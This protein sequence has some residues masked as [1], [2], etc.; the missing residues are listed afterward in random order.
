MDFT[1]LSEAQNGVIL[2][3][4]VITLAGVLAL[5]WRRRK[6]E[7]MEFFTTLGAAFTWVFVFA[8][9]AGAQYMV[10]FAPFVLLLSPRWWVA[11]TA[12]SAI[13]MAWFYDSTSGYVF[14][15]DFSFPKGPEI[16]YW[17][18]W[19]N[20]AWGTFV[21]LLCCRGGSWV[22]LEG[23]KVDEVGVGVVEAV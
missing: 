11:L 18:P 4:K 22:L 13:Y 1:G 9:G 7:G 2:G 6:L 14:P 10:W 21:A 8:P 20:L 16:A 3:L 23:R 19:M 15:W 5:A 12:G 17:G